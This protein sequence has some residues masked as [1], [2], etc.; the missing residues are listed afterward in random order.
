MEPFQ[1]SEP[2]VGPEGDTILRSIDGINFYIFRTILEVA[3]PFFRT[4]FS[5]PQPR[6]ANGAAESMD[7]DDLPVV[8]VGEDSTALDIALRYCYP[9]RKPQ[10]TDIAVV[11]RVLAAGLK[12]E[13]DVVVE[14]MQSLLVTEAIMANQ[15]IRAY[16]IACKHKLRDQARAA[17]KATLAHS[18][19]EFDGKELDEA[20]A[21]PLLYLMRYR[22]VVATLLCEI[23]NRSGPRPEHAWD[24]PEDADI[25]LLR[26]PCGGTP[27]LGCGYAAKFW[28]HFLIRAVPLISE[29]PHT[30]TIFEDNFLRP[31]SGVI[32][33]C[34]LCRDSH[35]VRMWYKNLEVTIRGVYDRTAD[36]VH[37]QFDDN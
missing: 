35:A 18:I 31:I 10:I 16:L 23:F 5:L 3:S 17:A 22:K 26:P 14:S 25:S 28:V 30:S 34:D 24:T 36:S 33:E 20:P 19:F 7:H 6:L 13:I 37:L 32:S 11:D 4:L 15:P 27:N 2:F 21:R 29:V 1:L 8:D 9:V 12:Y